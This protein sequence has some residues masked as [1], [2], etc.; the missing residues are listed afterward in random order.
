[1]C[2]ETVFSISV[3]S[4]TGLLNV[5]DK[6]STDLPGKDHREAKKKLM[7]QAAYIYKAEH[8]EMARERLR[9]WA[10]QW[11]PQAPLAVATLER[12]GCQT[13]WPIIS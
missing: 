6:A 5:A 3:A 4:F 8:A 10:Q 13:P 11:R 7:E 9:E 12:D 2:M 1:M